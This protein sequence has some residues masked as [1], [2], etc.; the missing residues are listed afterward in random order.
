MR[1]WTGEV[2]TH[3]E[4]NQVFVFGS[5]PEGRHGA[6][7]AK[8]AMKFGAIYGVGRGLQGQTFALITKN[9]RPNSLCRVSGFRYDRYGRKSLTLDQIRYNVTEMYETA[10]ENP[11][12]DFLVAYTPSDSESLC[13][14]SPNQ[15]IRECF[16]RCPGGVPSNVVFHEGFKTSS[17]KP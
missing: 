10:R 8:H 14:Y 4:P 6:G 17:D 7:A 11:D 5:N 12:K 15:L 9:L 1:Y 3:L 2:I 13:G 16:L